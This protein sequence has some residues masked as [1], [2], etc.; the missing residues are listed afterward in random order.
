MAQWRLGCG[1]VAQQ[2]LFCLI[3]S[4]VRTSNISQ[5]CNAYGIGFRVS[6]LRL[7]TQLWEFFFFF[8]FSALERSALLTC[9]STH[10]PSHQITPSIRQRTRALSKG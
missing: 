4:R 8:F 1:D 5:L 9:M 10:A 2:D 3:I 6:N 7:D